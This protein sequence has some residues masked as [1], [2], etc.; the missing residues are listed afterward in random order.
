MT[1]QGLASQ[2]ATVAVAAARAGAS[3][4]TIMSL[5]AVAY[6]LR[7]SR[8][9]VL[10]ITRK[11]MVRHLKSGLNDAKLKLSAQDKVFLASAV[12][13]L[14]QPR[15]AAEVAAEEQSL[16]AVRK[17]MLERIRQRGSR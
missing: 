12:A 17:V 3:P 6:E 4:Y 9:I 8:Q 11:D 1:P 10:E 14:E 13:L 2:I 5:D 7:T 16:Q 15:D